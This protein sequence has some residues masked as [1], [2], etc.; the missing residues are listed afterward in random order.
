[1]LSDRIGN[2][3]YTSQGNAYWPFDPRP[4]EIHI[5]TIAHHLANQCRF[6][7]AVQHK[8]DERKI[9]YSVAEHSV[10]CSYFV[11][12][13]ARE[14]LMHDAGEAFTG[15]LIRPLKYHPDFKENFQSLERKNDLALAKRFS[16][17]YPWPEE[18]H[19]ADNRMGITE[20]E[21]MIFT[22]PGHPSHMPL[23]PEKQGFPIKIQ[24]LAPYEAKEL[25]L[26]RYFQLFET[27]LSKQKPLS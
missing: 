17:T 13:F 1:M 6:N 11:P 26:Q 4:E 21:Q 27:N 22:N 24:M 20:I 10:L 8:T 12:F 25:F 18:V 7:G 15:D 2:Y 5:E 9:F 16:L 3:M 19:V 14:A 23:N